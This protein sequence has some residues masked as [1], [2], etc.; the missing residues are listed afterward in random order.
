MAYKIKIGN[1]A[2]FTYNSDLKAVGLHSNGSGVGA[3]M[4]GNMEYNNPTT[5]DSIGI[6]TLY[7]N[8][9]TSSLVLGDYKQLLGPSKYYVS[10]LTTQLDPDHAAL[11]PLS[12]PT[13]LAI[14]PSRSGSTSSLYYYARVVTYDGEKITEFGSETSLGYISNSSDLAYYYGLGA[15]SISGSKVI[16]FHRTSREQIRGIY[17]S[18]SGRT[19]TVTKTTNLSVTAPSLNTSIEVIKSGSDNKS[20]K[21]IERSRYSQNY[22]TYNVTVDLSASVSSQFI[23]TSGST[24]TLSENIFPSTGNP[25]EATDNGRS[26]YIFGGGSNTSLNTIVETFNMNGVNINNTSLLNYGS[27]GYHLIPVFTKLNRYS[28]DG[29]VLAVYMDNGILKASIIGLT[30][31]DNPAPYIKQTEAFDVSISIQ[32]KKYLTRFYDDVYVFAMGDALYPITIEEDSSAPSVKVNG[33]WKQGDAVYVKD[34]GLW[35]QGTDT[36]VKVNGIWREAK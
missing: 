28:G 3:V 31:E 7:Y 19:I 26:A 24:E 10:D 12:G 6:R 15:Y 23:F 1:P 16:V 17:L 30:D 33:L 13:C 20:Y 11:L 36:Y 34:K 21:V 8:K 25:V 27:R 18:I 35:K 5:S 29:D 9:A 32:Y 4:T 14:Y 2:I 22:K